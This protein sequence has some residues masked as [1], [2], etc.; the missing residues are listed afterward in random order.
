MATTARYLWPIPN[1]G[2]NKRLHRASMPTLLVWGER[3]GICP[4]QYARDFQA[5][6][7]DARLEIIPAAAHLPQ[8]EQPARLAELVRSFLR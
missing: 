7:P 6:L 2:L 4:P 8:V 5:L 1:R 3:D